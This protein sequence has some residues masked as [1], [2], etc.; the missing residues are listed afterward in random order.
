MK[1]VIIANISSILEFIIDHRELNSDRIQVQ[2]GLDGGQGIL[3]VCM[4][5]YEQIG[6][7]RSVEAD[8]KRL[9]YSDGAGGRQ[10]KLTSVKKL[11]V[12][13]AAPGV[14]KRL[15]KISSQ[16]IYSRLTSKRVKFLFFYS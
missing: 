8:R 11:M 16:L 2:L 5:I 7:C 10:A 12:A 9:K 3:K 15:D 1:P 13:A 14:Y 6:N 4:L